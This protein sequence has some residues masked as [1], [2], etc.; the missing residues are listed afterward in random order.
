M[1]RNCCRQAEVHVRARVVVMQLQVRDAPRFDSVR[2][3]E[4]DLGTHPLS[5]Y[6]NASGELIRDV[7]HP[8]LHVMPADYGEQFVL[9]DSSAAYPE[10][11]LT[12]EKKRT[13]A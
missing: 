5:S 6:K 1:S 10:F 3:T 9:F 7:M 13:S 11:L 12:L 2:S 4:G 8:R